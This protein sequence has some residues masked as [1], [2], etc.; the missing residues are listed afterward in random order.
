[1]SA[2]DHISATGRESPT[3]RRGSCQRIA[4]VLQHEHA[5]EILDPSGVSLF[6]VEG[7][8]VSFTPL[9]VTVTDH[10]FA[11]TYSVDGR[12]VARHH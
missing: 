8:L 9:T 10:V 6:S 5:V 3:D 2:D 11:L 7:D 1:M 4:A 12:L